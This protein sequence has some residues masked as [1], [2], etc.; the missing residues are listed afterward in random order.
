MGRCCWLL[1]LSILT[2]LSVKSS[3]AEGAKLFPLTA[4][5]FGVASPWCERLINPRRIVLMMMMMMM[6]MMM[7]FRWFSSNAVYTTCKPDISKQQHT[8]FST[9]TTRTTAPNCSMYTKT[10]YTHLNCVGKPVNP[11]RL[12]DMCIH[13]RELFQIHLQTPA[14]QCGDRPLTYQPKIWTT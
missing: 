2:V 8:V 3:K 11:K 9:P 6:M 5:P 7:S 12:D 1:L 13:V 4:P 14:Q 10:P